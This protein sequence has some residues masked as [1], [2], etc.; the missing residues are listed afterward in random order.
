MIGVSASVVK[1]YAPKDRRIFNKKIPPVNLGERLARLR[2]D[3]TQRELARR[4]GID[5]GTISRI[6]RDTLDPTYSTIAKLA[7]GLGV[8]P[9]AFFDDVMPQRSGDAGADLAE[10]VSRLQAEVRQNTREIQEVADRQASV[11]GE[12][13]RRL[14]AL[15][16]DRP[17]RSRRT[18]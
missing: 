1:A 6:E 13:R 12:V 4:A 14:D 17:A 5:A 2:G 9:A 11:A 3:I 7:K 15:E 8:P 16:A 18:G 10:T